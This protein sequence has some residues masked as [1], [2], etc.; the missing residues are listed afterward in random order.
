MT[1]LILRGR[2]DTQKFSPHDG[3][4]LVTPKIN[5]SMRSVFEIIVKTKFVISR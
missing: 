4:E 2:I 1:L 3:C 5:R